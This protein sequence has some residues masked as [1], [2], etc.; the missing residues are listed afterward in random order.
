MVIQLDL[1]V[2]EEDSCK[3]K[4][5]TVLTMTQG[6]RAKSLYN[7]LKKRYAITQTYQAVYKVLNELVNQ[8]ILVKEDLE[9]RVNTDWVKGEC[10][11]LKS[12]LDQLSK[13]Q[14]PGL[15]I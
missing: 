2:Y 4:I 15:M 14:V 10:E 8:K 5:F 6:M 12:L 9:Y 3:N 1:S 13:N 7:F 11:R